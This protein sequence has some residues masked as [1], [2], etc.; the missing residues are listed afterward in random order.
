MS[1]TIPAYLLP[2]TLDSADGPHLRV[3]YTDAS[4]VDVTLGTSGGSSYWF[5]TSGGAED[6]AAHIQAA[7]GTATSDSWSVEVVT[8][9]WYG[10]ITLSQS[11]G[12]K[13]PST[14]TTL[15]SSLTLRHLGRST[16]NGAPPQTASILASNSTNRSS[17]IWSPEEILT[18]D[19]PDTP[20]NI[21]VAHT[22]SGV[23]VFDDF[24][25]REERTHLHPIVWA[26]LLWDRYADDTD[27]QTHVTD[28]PTGDI[29]ATL[30]Q[31]L[32]EMRS[33][34]PSIPTVRVLTDREDDG[35][36]RDMRILDPALY[37]PSGWIEVVSEAPLRYSVMGRLA[38]V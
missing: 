31:W 38:L 23:G 33:L 17:L 34:G 24:G 15:T 13:T 16:L 7:L 27:H 11:S 3:T 2:V 28:M 18:M 26:A 20:R 9:G 32:T 21:V 1:Y 37:I 35:S 12:A 6:L 14:I 22:E 19:D 8:S 10:R 30:Q 4:T 29:N 36:A 25:G 5:D